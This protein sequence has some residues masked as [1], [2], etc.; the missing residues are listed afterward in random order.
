MVNKTNK[1]Q[2][3]EIATRAPDQ[4]GLAIGR[5]RARSELSQ[6]ALAKSAGVRQATVSKVEKGMG[7]T[8]LETI[9]SVCAALGLEVVLRPRHSRGGEI[10]SG[11]LF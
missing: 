8:A 6:A 2:S 11:D 10:K 4:L 3:L 7:T 1:T 5:F 9:Y